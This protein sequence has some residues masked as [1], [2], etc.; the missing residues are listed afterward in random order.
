MT[1]GRSLIFGVDFDNTIAG[2]EGIFHQVATERRLIGVEVPRS[3]DSV[4]DAVRLS[5]GGETEWQKLQALVYGP[6]MMEAIPNEGAL[7]FFRECNL[8]DVP[9]F[10]ISH[11]SKF[12]NLDE[13]GTNLREAALDWLERNSFFHADIGLTKTKVHFENTRQ[14][15]LAKVTALGCTHFVDDLPET[16]LDTAF[17]DDVRKIIYTPAGGRADIPGAHIVQDW[18]SVSALLSNAPVSVRES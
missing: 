17:P 5:D 6:R 4:R 1:N 11:K 8:R 7:S 10:V 14:E 12:A 3:K 15:K 18:A 9:V 16:F 2:Y 13:T